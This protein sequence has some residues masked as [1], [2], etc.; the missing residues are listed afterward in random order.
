MACFNLSARFWNGNM[1]YSIDMTSPIH[2]HLKIENILLV[3]Q[4]D[5]VSKALL[6]AVDPIVK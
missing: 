1:D 4:S 6:G 3:Q 2:P 5:Y